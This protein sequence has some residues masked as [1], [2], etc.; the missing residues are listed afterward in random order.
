ML[1]T[2]LEIIAF[3]VA[4]AI[5]GVV[6]GWVLRGTLGREQV[7]ISEL[8]T[9]L[10]QLKKANRESKAA[11][12]AASSGESAETSTSKAAEKPAAKKES[13]RTEVKATA[14]PK[15]V[16]KTK[17]PAKKKAAAK[18]SKNTSA[19]KSQAEREADQAA[20][21]KAFAE[22]V[23]RVGKSDAQDNLT[24]I[25]GVGKKYAGMLN[26]LGVSSYQQIAMLRK[27]EIRTLAA[28]LGVLDD[29][30]EKEDWV[31]SAKTLLKQAKK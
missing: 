22:V 25:F 24:K 10:R 1:L 4:A 27:A 15:A 29:R 21:V 3:M 23:E 12:A 17:A 28:A 11:L 7:E 9:Q 16:V 31:A 14:K 20:G 26:D 18:A 13:A 19:R 30:L 5:I 6:L 8:R 2:A